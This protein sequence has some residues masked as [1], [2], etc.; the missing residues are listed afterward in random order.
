MNRIT[1]LLLATCWGSLFVGC[2][3]ARD[4]QIDLMERELRAQEDYI[5][6]LEDY[7]LDYSE[8]L[9]QCRCTQPV[10]VG[11][12]HSAPQLAPALASSSSSKND[13]QSSSR[14]TLRPARENSVLEDSEPLPIHSSTEELESIEDLE[15]PELD[16]KI[17]DPISERESPSSLISVS[18]E[19]EHPAGRE[20]PLYDPHAIPDPA[21]FNP[22]RSQSKRDAVV[23]ATD[24]APP[25]ETA[26]E[27]G[28]TTDQPRIR[29]LR[30][31]ERLVITHVFR[32]A[33]I[34]A[35]SDTP[36]S[37]LAVV[38]ARDAR[39]EPADFAGKVSL[40]VMTGAPDQQQRVKRWD[41]TP[42]ETSLAWQTSHL[43]DGLH[44]ELPLEAADLPAADC[45]LWVRLETFQGEKLLT[46]VPFETT[47]LVGIDEAS[48]E[49]LVE[50]TIGL[51]ATTLEPTTLANGEQP[52]A[53]PLRR[54]QAELP[55]EVAVAQLT[56]TTAASSREPT[57]EPRWRA[58]THFSSGPNS[59]FATT[60]T[61]KHW[62]NSTLNE[63]A[64]RQEST[65]TTRQRW[66]TRR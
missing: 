4:N 13:S 58:A 57:E 6:E 55:E 19:E 64:P 20:E 28:S 26:A 23:Q 46:K 31:A 21:D 39:N 49:N 1:L 10:A 35:E 45:E 7:V 9:R 5:Y 34:S 36:A 24:A 27:D 41:F 38:E 62:G 8:K 11:H 54:D 40:M 12:S 16:L 61:N 3:S 42:E 44:L 15:I 52:Q 66:T 65:T 2:R 59:G 47:Q 50:S 48:T 17:G 32:G 33:S 14:E 25:E 60:A 22:L 30:A 37:L 43:G 18:A 63:P 53:N 29:E 56:Q 51:E